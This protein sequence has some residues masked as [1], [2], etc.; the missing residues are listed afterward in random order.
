MTDPTPEP[1]PDHPLTPA[2]Q[3][4]W[5]VLATLYGEQ[6]GEEIDHDLHAREPRGLE[7]VVLPQVGHR[8][9]SK[10][11]RQKAF[12]W[13][14]CRMEHQGVEVTRLHEKEWRR[15][16]GADVP[17]PGLPD[18]A[19]DVDFEWSRFF[20]HS[21]DG[22]MHLQN[23]RSCQR[24]DVW[25]ERAVRPCKLLHRRLVPERSVQQ[26]VPGSRSAVFGG[27][28][29]F[30][31]ATFF[32]KATGSPMRPSAEAAW[33]TETT[34]LAG[35]VFH[36]ATFNRHA[37]FIEATFGAEMRTQSVSFADCQFDKPAE[38]P[39]R[40]VPRPV[41]DLLRRHHRR[42]QRLHR[43][44]RPLAEDD[45]AGPRAGPRILRRHPPHARQAGPARGGAFLLPPRDGIRRAD[46][47]VL[48][49]AALSPLRQALRLRPFHRAPGRVARRPDRD[50]LGGHLRL[51][52]PLPG[53]CRG[54][55]VSPLV[56]AS[57]SR[58]PTPCP[59]SA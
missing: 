1:A 14:N 59:S 25:R 15:R 48:A 41:P 53:R 9:A 16:N 56:E 20:E 58:S 52:R 18:V 28:S 39:Q 33:F 43:Q 54:A 30:A 7:C 17:Y 6:E 35:A 19:K 10:K 57:A 12:R 13:R 40:Q 27:E 45:H 31:G 21:G 2:N 32:G 51:A 22:E 4:P 24:R 36:R 29:I 37:T 34:F 55:M 44:A 23:R 8:G 11:R 3:N 47:P 42:P 50:R 5:Y 49:A 46:R 26:A 38:L